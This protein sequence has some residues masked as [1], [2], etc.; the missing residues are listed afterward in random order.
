MA[1]TVKSKSSSTSRGGGWFNSFLGWGI[2]TLLLWLLNRNNSDSDSTSSMQASPYTDSNSNQIGQ[3]IPVALGRV[4]IKNP[5]ISYYGAFRADIYTEE[6]GAHSNL[7]I[8][9]WILSL[10]PIIL[11]VSEKDTIKVTAGT[12]VEIT[13]RTTEAMTIGGLPAATVTGGGTSGMNNN[14]GKIGDV[15]KQKTPPSTTVLNAITSTGPAPVEGTIDLSGPGKKRALIMQALLNFI[16]WLLSYLIGKHLLRTTIQ[17]GFKYY[18]G[19][20]HILCWTDENIGVKRLWMNVYDT[21]VEQSTETGVWDNDNHIAYKKDNP[22]GISAY[23]DND[24][25]FGGVDEGGGFIGEVR[26]YFGTYEQPKDSWMVN[27]MKADTIEEDLRG[28]TPRYPMFLTCV[29]SDRNKVDGAY[30]GKQSTMPE[31]WFEVVNYPTK[32]YEEFKSDLFGLYSKRIGELVDN[33]LAYISNQDQSVQTYMEDYTKEL[34]EA[35]GEYDAYYKAE[36][37]KIDVMDRARERLE[38]AERSGDQQV[39][40]DAQEEYDKAKQE[41]DEAHEKTEE[42]FQA[43]RDAA[44]AVRDN[45]PQTNRDEVASLVDP[46]DTLL[47]NGVWHLGKLDE[48]LN[49]AEAIYAILT[50]D[51]WGCNYD[52]ITDI[53]A[54]SLLQLGITCEEERLGVSCLITSEAQAGSYIQK[55]LNHINGIMYDNPYTG[56]LTFKLI[57]GDYDPSTLPIFNPSNCESM[58]FTRLDWSETSSATT[59]SFTHASNKYVDGTVIYQDV[60][61]RFIT[62]SYKESSVEGVYYTVPKNAGWLAKISQ[63][64]SGYP[65]STVEFTTNR[66]GHDI[67]LGDPIIVHWLS[68]GIDNQIYRVTDID[69]ATLTANA[70]KV[71]AIED[72]YGFENTRYAYAEVPEWTNPKKYAS[73]IQYYMYMEMPYE[74]TK[75]LD[76]YVNAYAARPTNDD[77][78]YVNY[79]YTGTEYARRTRTNDWSMVAQLVYGTKEIYD[80]DNTGFEI[81]VIGAQARD[82]FDDKCQKILDYPSVYT[83]KSNRNMMVIDGEILTYDTMIKLPNGHY[84]LTNVIHGVYDTIPRDHPAYSKVYFLDYELQVDDKRV[85]TEG[86]FADE[87]YELRSGTVDEEEQFNIDDIV[88]FYTKRRSECPSPMAN[89]KFAAERGDKTVY[90]YNYPAGTIFGHDIN[91]TYNLRNKFNQSDNINVHNNENDAEPEDTT[92][93][94]IKCTCNEKEFEFKYDAVVEVTDDDG[95]V[96]KE[97]PTDITLFWNEFCVQ[98]GN[99]LQRVSDVQLEIGSYNKQKDLYSFDHYDKHLIYH[100]P[101]VVGIIYPQDGDD[102]DQMAKTYADSIVTATHIEIPESTY[103]E[104]STMTFEDAPLILVADSTTTDLSGITG[105]DG[106]RYIPSTKAYRVDGANGDNDAVIHEIELKEEYV[107]QNDFT[108][109]EGVN[110]RYYRYRNSNWYETQLYG[111]T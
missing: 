41:A 84:T 54:Q 102:V 64:A 56:R 45:Y 63:L 13:G 15:P 8:W 91:F 4:M 51:L 87:Q 11:A 57:R 2:S 24:Q 42:T 81:E 46:L 86:N 68:Y 27:E 61:N 14:S 18:L 47:D 32:L 72:I 94:Y 101:R 67:G 40:T 37:L 34:R 65:L 10:I 77:D 22:T 28:L 85:A 80:E 108:R 55:I 43:L 58:K 16:L 88:T 33:I 30:I 20:Q 53:D 93:Y 78:Y 38:E 25:M 95:N 48:D 66:F 89:L 21:E 107:L 106:V 23:I 97:F 44:D 62:R 26:F 35:K 99:R 12:G 1:A 29:V 39:I 36:Q 5:L 92:Q 71:T 109:A 50:N 79:R 82:L 74:W 75:S 100:V 96:T 83:N 110:R 69:Y 52:R 7:D 103:V 59:V 105:Q 31:M 9:P 70:I 17:K 3:P 90:N 98:M 49:P 73:S 111:E 104:F 19:W 60:A 6:Y 76:T